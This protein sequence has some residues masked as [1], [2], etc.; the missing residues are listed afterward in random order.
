MIVNKRGLSTIIVALLLI[1]LSLAAVGIVWV[2]VQ[3]LIEGGAGDVDLSS[4]C[5]KVDVAL[6]K[7]DCNSGTNG[8]DCE[9]TV[10]RKDNGENIDGIKLILANETAT[11]N[12][13]Y[14]AA[15]N[16]A[17]LEAKTFSVAE[18]GISG[19]NNVDIVP[20]FKDEVGNEQLCPL[21]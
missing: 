16:I 6:T 21:K 20:Y 7:T 15:G 17:S 8:D 1:V 2:V 4:K 14:D 19:I 11:T 9:I 13:I 3:N 12:Y 5:L 10:M 18:T